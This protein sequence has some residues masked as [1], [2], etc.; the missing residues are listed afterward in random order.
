MIFCGFASP[1][2]QLIRKTVFHSLMNCKIG[3]GRDKRMLN[4]FISYIRAMGQNNIRVPERTI[5]LL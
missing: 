4:N 5:R 1:G 3:H 2:H